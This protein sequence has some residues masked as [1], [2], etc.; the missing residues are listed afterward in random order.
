MIDTVPAGLTDFLRTGRDK[1]NE[2]AVIKQFERQLDDRFV[3]LRNLTLPDSEEKLGLVLVGPTGAWHLELL[4]LASLSK[5]GPTWMHWD[6]DQQSIQVVQFNDIANTARSRLAELRAFLA[7]DGIP[8]YQLTFVPLLKIP[9]DFQVPGVERMFFLE[10][11]EKFAKQELKPDGNTK[12]NVNDAVSLFTGKSERSAV[13]GAPI[14]HSSS[15]ASGTWLKR[16]F[17]QYGNLTGQ[18]LVLVAGFALLNLCLC[19][20]LMWALFLR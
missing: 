11:I 14:P 8:A 6:H 17:P 3:L 4:H 15:S 7:A 18:Q 2:D 10:D 20:V 9:R 19:G 5:S 13:I 12:I 16:T 1:T